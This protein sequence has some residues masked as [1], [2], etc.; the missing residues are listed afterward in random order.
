MYFLIGKNCVTWVI[1]ISLKLS[2]SNSKSH[3][4]LTLSTVSFAQ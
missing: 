1:T 4:T 3:T 2:M